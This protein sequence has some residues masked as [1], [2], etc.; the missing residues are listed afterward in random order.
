MRGKI[1]LALLFTASAVVFISQPT[2]GQP[3][4]GGKKKRGGGMKMGMGMDAGSTFDRMANGRSSISINE[5]RFGKTIATQ[6]AEET[7]ITSGMITRA[8]YVEIMDRLQTQMASG[9]MTMGKG[10]GGA[11]G[12][13]MDGGKKKFQ[14]G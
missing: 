5:I 3:G 11:P 6:Y 7:G 9:T 13:G 4:G 2:R 8:Q 1:I 10:P 12:G 14:F